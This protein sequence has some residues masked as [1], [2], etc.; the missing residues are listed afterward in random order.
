MYASRALDTKSMGRKSMDFKMHPDTEAKLL[1][2]SSQISRSR[3]PSRMNTRPPSLAASRHS[4]HESHLRPELPKETQQGFQNDDFINAFRPIENED[5]RFEN[6]P[7]PT[8]KIQR[9]APSVQPE[10]IIPD[11]TEAEMAKVVEYSGLVNK[12]SLETE[13][14]LETRKKWHQHR[15]M[16]NAKMISNVRSKSGIY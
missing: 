10:M 9:M 7:K 1:E 15:F 3:G 2:I 12:K 6:P 8:P 14:E 5:T 4:L 13:D 16:E 11:D